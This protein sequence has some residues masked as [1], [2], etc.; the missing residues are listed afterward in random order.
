MKPG[1]QYRAFLLQYHTISGQVDYQNTP[2]SLPDVFGATGNTLAMISAIENEGFRI[3]QVFPNENVRSTLF[4]L[5]KAPEAFMR[6]PRLQLRL[7]SNTAPGQSLFLASEMRNESN[8]AANKVRIYVTGVGKH[9]TF[10]TVTRGDTAIPVR[11]PYAD[12]ALHYTAQQFPAVF[13]EYL[14]DDGR[15]FQQVGLLNQY[16]DASKRL[17][18]TGDGLEAPE[19]IERF[20]V[21][22]DAL[23]TI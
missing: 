22:H 11:I 10:G 9:F 17:T 23:E 4:I 7:Q 12:E 13:V 6:P 21:A 15:K 18:Y 3:A 5:E 8:T 14:S 20:K 16:Q 19:E 1:Y 2:L